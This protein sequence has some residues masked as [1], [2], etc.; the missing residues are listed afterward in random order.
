MEGEATNVNGER[1]FVWAKILKIKALPK[2]VNMVWRA[3]MDC[4]LTKSRLKQR[5]IV[6][7][8]HC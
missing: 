6:E 3:T 8:D 5:H 4:I 1:G 2:M 7:E